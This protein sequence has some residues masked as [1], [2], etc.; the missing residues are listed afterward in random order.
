MFGYATIL[1]SMTQGRAIYTM[2]F[3]YYLEVPKSIAEEISE[4]SLGSKKKTIA[5]A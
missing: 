3:E 4:K 5:T 2:Q 1:R